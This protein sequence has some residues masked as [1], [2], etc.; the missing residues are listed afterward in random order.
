MLH[1]TR[2]SNEPESLQSSYLLTKNHGLH[3]L[4]LCRACQKLSVRLM[5]APDGCLYLENL[6]SLLKTQRTCRFCAF[7]AQTIRG[8]R[9]SSLRN[10]LVGRDL[11]SDRKYTVY[12]NLANGRLNVNL[13]EHAPVADIELYCDPGMNCKL[14]CCAALSAKTGYRRF[15]CW[16]PGYSR[17]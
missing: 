7:I 11:G 12:L 13:R 15:I 6:W 9:A 3:K 10:Q 8:T 1:F 14:A 17:D 4:S 16:Q 2:S 5:C